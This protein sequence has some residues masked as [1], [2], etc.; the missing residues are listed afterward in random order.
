[1]RILSLIRLLNRN[2]MWA[3]TATVVLVVM[4][5]GSGCSSPTEPEP[6]LAT[7]VA[8][9]QYTEISSLRYYK[10]TGL[11]DTSVCDTVVDSVRTIMTD[12]DGSV[13]IESYRAIR[14]FFGTDTLGQP[15]PAFDEN[16]KLRQIG[17]LADTLFLD[18]NSRSKLLVAPLA[19]SATWKVDNRG[20]ITAVVIGEETLT[21]NSGI[22]QS[23]RVFQG[24]VADEWYAPGLGR[25]QYEETDGTLGRVRGILI[26]VDR[27]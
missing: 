12:P 24:A 5:A 1:M 8:S 19:P 21:L 13:W 26:A 14:H 2:T 15:I 18:R 7:D 6:G 11:S 22:V 23:W 20:A 4:V 16:S 3:M 27:F 10:V 17:R 9:F 25:V